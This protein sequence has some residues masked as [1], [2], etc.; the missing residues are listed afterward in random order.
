MNTI[1][2]YLELRVELLETKL[3]LARYRDQDPRSL[4]AKLTEAQYILKGLKRMQK[5][6]KKGKQTR[7]QTLLSR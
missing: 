4:E 6:T 1:I 2:C 3:E 7:S 5:D